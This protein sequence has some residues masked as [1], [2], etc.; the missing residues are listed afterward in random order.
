GLIETLLDVSR[1]STGGFPLNFAKHDLTGLTR[2]VVERMQP[3]AQ[4]AGTK[5]VLR[6]DGPI[7]GDWDALRLEQ[8]ITNLLSNALKYGAGSPV[9]VRVARDSDRAVIE[10]TDKGP[11]IPED[12][13]VRI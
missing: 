4:G 11:G 8:V 3:A 5:I 6:T 9:E 13:L 12:D 2:D 10:V 7:A 1:I